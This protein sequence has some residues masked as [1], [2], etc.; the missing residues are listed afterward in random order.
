MT[1][2]CRE[3]TL[4][5][6]VEFGLERMAPADTELF[7]QDFFFREASNKAR[8]RIAVIGLGIRRRSSR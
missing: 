4:Q 6:S 1:G 7:V 8:R 3:I 2:K 5:A